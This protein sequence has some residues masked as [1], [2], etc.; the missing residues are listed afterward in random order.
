MRERFGFSEGLCPVSEDISARTMA[1]PFHARLEVEDQAYV[2]ERL[3]A[4][5]A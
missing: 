3:R 1:I 5:I 2:V 4:A